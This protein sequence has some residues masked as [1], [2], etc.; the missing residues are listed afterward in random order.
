MGLLEG[1]NELINCVTWYLLFPSPAPRLGQDS[2][3][4]L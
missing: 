1:L 2:G 3:W 4:G